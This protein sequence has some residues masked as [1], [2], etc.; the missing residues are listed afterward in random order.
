[1]WYVYHTLKDLSYGYGIRG[2]RHLIKA[3]TFAKQCVFSLINLTATCQLF[4]LLVQW[5]ILWAVL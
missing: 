2:S 5:Y 4:T 1:M 3:F